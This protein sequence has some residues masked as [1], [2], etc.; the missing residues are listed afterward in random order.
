MMMM[1][2]MKTKRPLFFVGG[3]DAIVLSLLLSAF[4][5]ANGAPHGRSVKIEFYVAQLIL[6]LEKAGALPVLDHSLS[7]K[8]ATTTGGVGFAVL[9][10]V[11]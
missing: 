5:D 6:V 3:A 4:S 1:M 11:V 8:V 2:M 7:L 9:L 10:F